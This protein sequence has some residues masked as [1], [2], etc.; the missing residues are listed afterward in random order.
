VISVQ[1][2][3]SR[4][5]RGSKLDPFKDEVHRLLDEDAEMESQ[6]IRELLMEQGYE[7]GKTLTDD[8]V[9]EVRVV[10]VGLMA[11]RRAHADEFARRL[12]RAA[13]LLR[14]RTPPAAR[15]ALQAEHGLSDR[16]PPPAQPHQPG[17]RPRRALRCEELGSALEQRLVGLAA[18]GHADRER[19]VDDRR[20]AGRRHRQAGLVLSWG[21]PGPPARPTITAD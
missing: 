1:P 19:V 9:R 10:P 20:V 8:Y 21:R 3:Y 14:G 17:R 12:N 4:P 15:R 5:A 2:S 6:R 7:G 11:P 13:D 16:R 18:V